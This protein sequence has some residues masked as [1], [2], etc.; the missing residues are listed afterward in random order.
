MN[1]QQQT[2]QSSSTG[3]ITFPTGVRKQQNHD[4]IMVK[5]YE[6]S[7]KFKISKG[8]PIWSFKDFLE[9]KLKEQNTELKIKITGME[10]DYNRKRKNDRNAGRPYGDYNNIFPNQWKHAKE[11][12]NEIKQNKKLLFHFTIAPTQAGKTGTSIAILLESAMNSNPKEFIPLENCFILTGINSKTWKKQTLERC[13]EFGIQV[14]K[15]SDLKKLANKMKNMRNVRI[16]WDEPQFGSKNTDKAISYIGKFFKDTGINNLDEMANRNIVVFP[17][18]ATPDGILCDLERYKDRFSKKMFEQD[19]SYKG[20][21]YFL[22][23]NWIIDLKMDISNTHILKQIITDITTKYKKSKKYSI[24]RL[25][26]NKNK[27]HKTLILTFKK[28]CNDNNFDFKHFHTVGQEHYVNMKQNI[29]LDC[30]CLKNEPTKHTIITIIEKLRCADTIYRKHIGVCVERYIDSINYSCHNQGLP[31]RVCGHKHID[32]IEPPIIYCSKK[33]IKAHL[34]LHKSEFNNTMI[35]YNSD[36]MVKN[37]TT[38]ILTSKNT[39]TH[40]KHLIFKK[41]GDILTEQQVHC[42][43]EKVLLSKVYKYLK[44]FDKFV[45]RG[46]IS[47]KLGIENRQKI[48]FFYKVC[49][50]SPFIEQKIENNRHYYRYKE[51][52]YDDDDTKEEEEVESKEQEEVES[53]VSSSPVASYLPEILNNEDKR[54]I[55]MFKIWSKP[56]CKSKISKFMKQINPDK[57]Y[58]NTEIKKILS[59]NNLKMHCFYHLFYADKNSKGNNAGYGKIFVKINKTQCK[60]NPSSISLYKK[61]FK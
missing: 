58:E 45:R 16:I 6:N 44:Q 42:K 35:H 43:N 30:D 53:K 46:R 40:P 47:K 41:E 52:N 21:Q 54:F 57:M 11:V 4:Y 61:Y 5:Q 17:G 56:L 33:A 27:K 2:N 10:D 9:N 55:K 12:V 28:M 15:R 24:I 1:N 49:L 34:K 19:I 29:I 22:E 14:I 25:P 20:L 51:T 31:G 38:G 60:L 3:I 36:T 37:K 8:Q 7:N 23:K 48:Q 50:N 39:C 26:N 32:E 13:K 18:S 59:D